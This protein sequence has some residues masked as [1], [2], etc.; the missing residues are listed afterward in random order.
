MSSI[1]VAGTQCS[2]SRIST[3]LVTNIVDIFV[4]VCVYR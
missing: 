4:N 1:A 2:V 3:Q